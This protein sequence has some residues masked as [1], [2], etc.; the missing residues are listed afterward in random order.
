MSDSDILVE[1]LKK[2]GDIPG[3]L[4]SLAQVAEFHTPFALYIATADRSN[5]MWVFDDDMVCEMLGGKDI[6]EKTFRSVFAEGVDRDQGILFYVLK[7]VGPAYVVKLDE[8]T[9]R[10][11]IGDLQEFL[12]PE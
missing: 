1:S 2:S 7:K 11:V 9:I 12:P 8:P 3:I 6:H 4:E 5:C 10:G